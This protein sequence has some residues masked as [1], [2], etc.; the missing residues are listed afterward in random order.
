MPYLVRVTY[1]Q[2]TFFKQSTTQ[3][4]RLGTCEKYFV[5]PGTTF[6]ALAVA[7]AEQ[8]RTYHY[9]VTFND[10]FNNAG[11]PGYNT[12]YVYKDHVSVEDTSQRVCLAT[13]EVVKTTSGLNVRDRPDT[14]ARV[15]R[16]LSNGTK[17]YAFGE[18]VTNDGFRWIQIKSSPTGNTDGWVATDYLKLL[19]VSS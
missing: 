9:K 4:D 2:G 14:S 8:D 3:A 5:E 19:S 18:G 17:V 15:I 12:W 11:C 1:P 10:Q 13:L 16:S 7:D 6:V